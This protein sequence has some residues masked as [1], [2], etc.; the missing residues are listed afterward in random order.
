MDVL[1]YE[2]LKTYHEN[3]EKLI[4]KSISAMEVE[5]TG[6]EKS[7]INGNLKINGVETT[8]YTPQEYYVEY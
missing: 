1:T 6:V 4:K 7:E 2:G 8:V 3:N 5:M